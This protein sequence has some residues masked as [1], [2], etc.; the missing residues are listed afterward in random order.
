LL[1]NSSILPI[2]ILPATSETLSGVNG[3]IPLAISSALTNYL[4]LN[5]SGK[6]VKDALVFPAPLQPETM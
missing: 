2:L 3:E 1:S 5:I 6:T 4:Q